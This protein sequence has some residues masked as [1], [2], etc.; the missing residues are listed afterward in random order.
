[1][2]HS[3]LEQSSLLRGFELM[4]RCLLDDVFHRIHCEA[5]SVDGNFGA[6]RESFGFTTQAGEFGL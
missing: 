5:P 2:E 3:V 4:L 6:G 1:L